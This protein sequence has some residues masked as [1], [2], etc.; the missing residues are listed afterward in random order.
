MEPAVYEAML[1]VVLQSVELESPRPFPESV[2]EALRRVVPCDSLSYREWTEQDGTVEQSSAA[3]DLPDRVPLWARYYLYQQDDPMPCGH[4]G[5]GMP[6][7]D[8][9]GLPLTIGD[10][11]SETR[12]RQT[13]LYFEICRPFGVRDVL[14]LHLPTEDGRASSFVFDRSDTRFRERDRAA[15]RRLY[16]FLVQLRRNAR[17]RAA[18]LNATETLALLTPRERVVL[19]RAAAGETN[20][21]IARALFVSSTTVRRHLEHVYVKLGV[22]NRAAASAIY[23]AGY[24]AEGEMTR[25]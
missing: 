10:V 18:A 12:F 7:P 16:P 14:K 5:S 17:S 9:I 6:V 25:S 24:G 20:K 2:T 11:T 13:G 22:P 19:A 4:P 8:L 3:E 15:L 21:E 23:V 1:D